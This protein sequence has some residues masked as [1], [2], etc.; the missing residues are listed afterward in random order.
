MSEEWR[1]IVGYEGLYKVSNIGNVASLNYR[2]T[3]RSKLLKSVSCKGYRRVVVSKNGEKRNIT[4]HRAVAM[5]FIVNVENKPQINHI[6]EIKYDNRVENLEWVTAKEN[7]NHGTWKVRTT[8]KKLKP[9]TQ[10]T[11]DWRFVKRWSSMSSTIEG[12]FVESC[13]SRCCSGDRS[14][15]K[16]YKW[17]LCE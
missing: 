8:N 17:R 7:L 1:D 3:G 14:E 11:L 15:H 9:V 4:V 13:V 2:R 10:F 16:G 6:N 5:A 12:G